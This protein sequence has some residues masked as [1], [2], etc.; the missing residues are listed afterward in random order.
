MTPPTPRP[1]NA[2]AQGPGY[3][4]GQEPTN[5][6]GILKTI[7]IAAASAGAGA[8]IV[9]MMQQHVFDES[10]GEIA[11]L[12]Q[13]LA[14]ERARASGIAIPGGTHATLPAPVAPPPPGYI[15]LDVPRETMSD[16]FWARLAGE[17]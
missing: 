8:I 4:V 11:K 7:L 17:D 2:P 14:E 1:P 10:Q 5:G 16:E 9:K 12:R 13:E 6:W 3:S 15:R